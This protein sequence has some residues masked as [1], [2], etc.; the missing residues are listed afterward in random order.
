MQQ[1]VGRAVGE[2]VHDQLRVSVGKCKEF[3]G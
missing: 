2:T 1:A 3:V